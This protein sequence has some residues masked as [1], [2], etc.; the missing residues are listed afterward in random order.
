MLSA[1]ATQAPAVKRPMID[2]LLIRELPQAKDL[3]AE[4]RWKIG[5]G[6]RTVVLSRSGDAFV[7][8]QDGTVDWLDCGA[9]TCE[10]VAGSLDEFWQLL[11]TPTRSRE[12][13]LTPVI[14][15][16]ISRHG[17]FPP[18][19]C[20]GFTT[21]PILGGSYALDNRFLISATEHLAGTGDL[22]RQIRDIPDGTAVRIKIV[23]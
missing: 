23:P 7:A 20:L 2:H 6:P 11:E 1:Y 9:G 5:G 18:A 22:N 13:L 16:F 21:L 17:P 12:L 8:K 4:W 14:E 3:L 15:E 10:Q 19:T